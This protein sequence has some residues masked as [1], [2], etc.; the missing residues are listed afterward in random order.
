[1]KFIYFDTPVHYSVERTSKINNFKILIHFLSNMFDGPYH[2]PL[3]EVDITS[4]GISREL[5][6]KNHIY[7]VPGIP[8]ILFSYIHMIHEFLL[9][10]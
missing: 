10:C 5:D 9:Y 6:I 4:S 3:E 7:F 1:M 2:I 8:N